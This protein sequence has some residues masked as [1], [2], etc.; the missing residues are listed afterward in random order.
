MRLL[1]TYEY[2][3]NL[4]Q[5]KRH[6]A[7]TYKPT[8]I[9]S[10]NRKNIMRL[11]TNLQRSSHT[12]EKTLCDYLQTYKDRFIQ[13]KI[14]YAI[15]YKLTKIISCNRKDIM[16]LPT[17]LQRSSHST[18]KTLCDYLRTYKN[19]LMQQKRHDVFTYKPTRCITHNIKT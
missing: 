10:F 17:N 1:I 6:C 19:H 3:V 7:I 4:M 12:T 14:H 16:R 18:E 11:L 5:Q 9:I 15:T 8:K 2:K 13:H